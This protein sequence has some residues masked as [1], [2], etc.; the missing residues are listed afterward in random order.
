MN[1]SKTAAEFNDTLALA[2]QGHY[3]STEELLDAKS[4]AADGVSEMFRLNQAL[5][6]GYLIQQDTIKRKD[7]LLEAK[8]QTIESKDRTIWILNQKIRQLSGKGDVDN[9]V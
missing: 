6:E 8:V 2:R 4:Y 3:I 1:K 7:Q 9:R 5:L